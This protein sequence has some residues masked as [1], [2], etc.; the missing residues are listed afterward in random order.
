MQDRLDIKTLRVYKTLR[1]FGR[2]DGTGG[3]DRTFG[4]INLST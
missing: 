4:R 1:V 2:G 3:F